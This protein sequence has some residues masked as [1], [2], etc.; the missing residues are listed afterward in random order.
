MTTI[1][2][3]F[4]DQGEDATAFDVRRYN[5]GLARLH[6]AEH[7]SEIANAIIKHDSEYRL[8]RR[9]HV[10]YVSNRGYYDLTIENAVNGWRHRDKL[11]TDVEHAA[12]RTTEKLAAALHE[13]N[14]VMLDHMLGNDDARN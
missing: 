4:V 9:A 14:L 12:G 6:S 10:E 11:F 13:L 5:E 1:N 7:L 2:S 3:S 8:V